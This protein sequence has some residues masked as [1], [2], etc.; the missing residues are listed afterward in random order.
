MECGEHS[1]SCKTVAPH[2]TRTLPTVRVRVQEFEREEF[3]NASHCGV[4]WSDNPW[5]LQACS[6]CPHLPVIE[7]GPDT[8]LFLLAPPALKLGNL[9]LAP[10]V[11]PCLPL[12]CSSLLL[13]RCRALVLAASPCLPLP[14]PFPLLPRCCAR[15]LLVSP[16]LPLPCP[17]LLPLPALKVPLGACC[18][19]PA[20]V[21]GLIGC[22]AFK[23][24]CNDVTR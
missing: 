21:N 14:C 12:P 3:E 13:S 9:V 7:P 16:C 23:R 5:A 15:V 19:S 22:R 2:C 24:A 10:A 8:S 11:S 18:G 17:S 6:P 1:Q 20:P 4:E